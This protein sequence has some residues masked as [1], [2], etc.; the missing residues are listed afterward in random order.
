MS[1]LQLE[2]FTVVVMDARL[3]ILNFQE[4]HI[5]AHLASYT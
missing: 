3:A 5:K 1:M 4:N 2:A